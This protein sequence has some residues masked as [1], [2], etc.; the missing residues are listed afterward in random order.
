MYHAANGIGF[1]GRQICF[2]GAML[3]T[4]VAGIFLAFT[5]SLAQSQESVGSPADVAAIKQVFADFYG[6]F[7]R[8]DAQA[9]TD[10]FAPDAEFTN[11]FGI[12]VHG[13]EA[14][15]Q[16]F[17]ALFKGNLKAPIAPTPCATFI[18]MR[19]MWPL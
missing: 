15:Q 4:I 6:A 12:H 5:A 11:M 8:Q 2:Q 16:H 13:R 9:I 10:T 7:S 18:F 1:V 3:A 17:T 14:I 19:P